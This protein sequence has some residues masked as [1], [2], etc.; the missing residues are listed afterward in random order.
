MDADA[1]PRRRRR[2]IDRDACAAA[3][4][5]AA[6]AR[7]VRPHPVVRA[8]SARIA[9]SIRTRRAASAAR[10]RVRRR[11][12]RRPRVRAA[13]DLGPQGRRRC[14]SAAA[15]RA[16]SRRRRSTGCSPA[17]ARACRSLPDAEITLEA[18]PGTFE[19]AEVR[20]L[21]RRRRQ[22]PVARHPELRSDAI[23]RRSGRV[24]D[25]DEAR[26]AAEAALDD[27]RQRQLRP[28]VR[29][30]GADASTTRAPTSRRRSRSRR[31]TCRSIT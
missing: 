19:R 26:R 3:L 24:H 4:R 13:V 14:S 30:A 27:L 21:L 22:P 15:R 2:A 31:R 7:A 9:T 11:A 28:D 1:T 12:A 5:R 20:G 6:A 18:N 25:D 16:C 10:G 29:A 8:G 17:S 23:C